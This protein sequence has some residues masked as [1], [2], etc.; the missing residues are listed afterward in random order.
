MLKPSPCIMELIVAGTAE[1]I[2][3]WTVDT[4]ST[5]YVQTAEC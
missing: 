4:D 1:A 3:R 2:I 5:I